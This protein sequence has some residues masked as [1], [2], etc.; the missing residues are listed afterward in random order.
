VGKGAGAIGHSPTTP[1]T[2][3]VIKVVCILFIR[4]ISIRTKI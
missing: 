2:P 4:T 1:P 3:S